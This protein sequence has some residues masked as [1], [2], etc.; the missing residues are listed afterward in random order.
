[1]TRLLN[2]EGCRVEARPSSVA[3]LW[4]IQPV[5]R[6]TVLAL[7]SMPHDPGQA[8]RVARR[9]AA[10]WNTLRPYTAVPEPPDCRGRDRAEAEDG[11][12]TVGPVS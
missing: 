12:P 8:G 3:G 2:V 7:V 6:P 5:G 4:T 11:G 10:A 1:L 9:F